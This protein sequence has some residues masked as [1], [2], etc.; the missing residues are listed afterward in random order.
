MLMRLR[1]LRAGLRRWR[2]LR[3]QLAGFRRHAQ[4]D[5]AAFEAD[6]LVRF[7]RHLEFAQQHSPYYREVLAAHGVD[8]ATATPADVPVLTKQVLRERFDDIV[9]DRRITAAGILEFLEQ[10][11]DPRDLFLGEYRVL[12]TSGT[13]GQR[14]Y[15]AFSE[16][17]WVRA[18][19]Q[20]LRPEFRP[21]PG[22]WLRPYRIA[23]YGSTRGHY[24]GISMAT[25]FGGSGLR[26]VVDMRAFEI[27]APLSE[28]LPELD[29]FQPDFLIG[30]V[31]A[32]KSLAD[33]QL[34]GRLAIAPRAVHGGGEAMTAADAAVLRPAFGGD[35][36]NNYGC[37]EHLMMGLSTPDGSRIVVYDDDLILEIADDHV[38]VTNL[39]NETL[40]LFRHRID[41][42]VRRAPADDPRFPY[43]A[44]EGIVGRA[45]MTLMLRNDDGV[46]E[47]LLPYS[48]IGLY[49]PDVVGFQAR[50]DADAAFT[51]RV[52]VDPAVGADRQAAAL[53][54][55]GGKV[56]N[57]LDGKRM[58]GVALAVE[59]VDALV[60]DA[61]TGKFKVIVDA[62]AAH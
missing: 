10:S 53:A 1:E 18:M 30:F 24:G 44:L 60:P 50:I 22:R 4:L 13:S 37:N 49:V 45:E 29:R 41:D 21:P 32:L 43:L 19:A 36:R 12:H 58:R 47:A 15:L 25:P 48:F 14:V 34:A 42:F 40:P 59:E 28:T 31:S 11:S 38:L 3:D 5:R 46:V 39:Y 26:H 8:V 2:I 17:D 6:R 35:I 20:F 62:R 52:R 16:R 54:A 9:T 57:L 56:R 23:Y 27:D 55:I 7:R 51:L 33:A 61:R